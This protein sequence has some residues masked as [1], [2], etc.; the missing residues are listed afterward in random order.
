MFE[1]ARARRRG[2]DVRVIV[3]AASDSGILDLSNQK[4]VNTMLRNGIRVYAYPGMTHVKAAV[5]D[6]WACVGSANFD[7]LSLQINRELNLATSHA[8][9]V[10]TLLE[11]VFLPDF[12]MSTELHEP[13]PLGARHHLAEFIA[14]EF[15]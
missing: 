10:N 1:L 11:R 3:A 2:V 14:D 4:T 12:E 8:E 7:K 9:T 13:F 6:G 15:F 5:F